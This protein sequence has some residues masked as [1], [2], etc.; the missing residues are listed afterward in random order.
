M[1]CFDDLQQVAGLGG[2][3]R[4]QQPFVQDQKIDLFVELHRFLERAFS[5][6]DSQLIQKIRQ[7]DIF[8]LVEV[9]ARGIAESTCDICL[10][11]TRS[12]QNNDVVLF[13]NV[14]AG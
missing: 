1:P 14:I 4:R 5:S 10:S 7:P 6:S 11:S 12:A 8:D 3:E 2:C 13:R 9:A